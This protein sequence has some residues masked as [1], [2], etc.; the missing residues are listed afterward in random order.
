[1]VYRISAQSHQEKVLLF[2]TRA[3]CRTMQGFIFVHILRDIFVHL[4]LAIS[5]T[6]TNASMLTGVPSKNPLKTKG[7][8]RVFLQ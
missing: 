6:S 1:M 4:I 7:P 8:Q 2:L 5:H 3:Q